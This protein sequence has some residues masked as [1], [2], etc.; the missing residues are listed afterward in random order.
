MKLTPLLALL[1][2]SS[3][4]STVAR[5]ADK[6]ASNAVTLSFFLGGVECP[7]CMYSVWQSLN[8]VKGIADAEM[9]QRIESF[10]NVTFDPAVI[11][12]HQIAQA[13]S[14]AFAL[15]G[16]PYEAM[17]RLR[18]PGYARPGNAAKLDAVFARSKEWLEVETVDK[19]KGEFVLHFRPL[20]TAGADKGPAG[21]SQAAFLT[22]VQSPA[23]KGLGLALEFEKGE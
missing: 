16:K 17:L 18:V 1:V 12:A 14:G 19:T 11:S 2:S 5:A 6:P 3:L 15:H 22:E 13:V 10:A 21:W 9:Q 20:K 7:S 8:E 23:P 4:I